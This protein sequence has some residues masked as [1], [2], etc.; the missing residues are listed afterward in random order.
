MGR[1]LGY[2]GSPNIVSKIFKS[3]ECL[4]AEIRDRDALRGDNQR[5]QCVKRTQLT[6][7]GFEDRGTGLPEKGRQG[8][9]F[10]P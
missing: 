10:Y 6:A 8:D 5:Q 9:S 3:R 7:T 4:L 2:I 1:F